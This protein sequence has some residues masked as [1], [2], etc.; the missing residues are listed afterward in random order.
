MTDVTPYAGRTVFVTGASGIVGSWLVRSL[1]SGGA[2]VV[3]LLRDE[4]PRSEFF[5]SGD[6]GRVARVRGGLEDVVVLERA[7]VEYDVDAVFHLAAQ[8]QVRHAQR[9]PFGTLEANVRGTYNLLEAVR[10]AARPLLALAIAS[11]DKAYG[12]SQSLPYTEDHPLAGR[13]VYD[14]SK[15]AADLLASAYGNSY[16][17]PV[18]IARCGNVYGGGDLN[19]DRIV[20]GTVR[21]LLRGE[22]PIIRSDGTLRRDYLFVDDAV[23]A[24]LALGAALIDG[25]E[26]G[27]A[28]NFGHG[29]PVAVLDLVAEISRAVGRG[30]LAP[31]LQSSAPNEIPA[32]WLDATKAQTRL[33]WAPAYSLSEGLIRTTAWYRELL[34]DLQES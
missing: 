28:F 24:Y 5:R 4:D 22:R 9:Q 30:D 11:S 20:P 18:G 16:A 14:A 25:R 23:T 6:G 8:T 10:R 12:E 33:G 15:S 3:A 1:L 13:N 2:F 7:L 19:W 21:S 27:E 31:I 32:Q 29:K 17:L 34:D 26:W